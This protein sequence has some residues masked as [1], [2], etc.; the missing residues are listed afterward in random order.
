MF[1]KR[2]WI[3]KKYQQW[4]GVQWWWVCIGIVA[5]ISAMALKR[6]NWANWT[7]FKNKTLW[8]WLEL[9]IV[10]ASIA[11]LGYVFQRQQQKR[12]E[13]L[14]K[15][16]R[17]IASDEAKEEVLQAYFDRLSSLLVDKNILAIANKKGNKILVP[18]QGGG[19]SQPTEK[20]TAE[21]SAL[22]RASIDIIRAQ[23]LSILRRFQND[24]NR[25]TSVIR[26][27]LEAD[28]IK[29]IQLPLYDADLSDIDLGNWELSNTDLNSA[30]FR[31]TDL[32][33]TDFRGATLFSSDFRN[34]DLSNTD[35]SNTDLM[36]AIFIDTTIIQAIFTDAN[37]NGANFHNTN[38]I[39]VDFRNSNLS[40]T[41]FT[42][43]YVSSGTLGDNDFID[44]NLS[45]A[46]LT[47]ANFSG[48]DLTFANLTNA[49][50]SDINLTNANLSDVNLTNANLSDANLSGAI[51]L[52]TD[53]SATQELT[54]K[55]L[56][57][58]NGPL[59]CN[60]PLPRGI[61][62]TG[63]KDRDCNKVAYA[64]YQRYPNIFKSSKE[65]EELVSQFREE[66]WK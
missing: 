38:L 32:S 43:A 56:E 46:D 17:E 31:G 30:D 23:T 51:L 65:A 3:S 12:T 29:E 14:S 45:G 62:I 60:S 27:L 58:E 7:G 25:K 8:D 54:Q 16:Q 9:F 22:L 1:W 55:Q 63:G 26:F 41:K 48:A 5:L 35:F 42:N 19:S 59:I 53:L 37:L 21:Q 36:D 11:M 61:E 47:Y 18:G 6:G 40:S 39:G 15:E 50:L 24:K 57:G 33:S 34:A 66:T 10:P 2:L 64:L 4:W 49:N 44:T 52:S 20:I 28:I 13:F